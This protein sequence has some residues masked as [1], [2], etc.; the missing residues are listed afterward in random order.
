MTAPFARVGGHLLAEQVPL[1]AIASAVGTPTYV[2]SA[3]SLRSQFARLDAALAGV[4]HRIHYAMKANG[5]L[6][7]LRVLRAAG[8]HVDCVSSG[9]LF[10]ARA[11]G[12]EPAEIIVGGVGKREDEI[13]A[14][15]AAGVAC[16]TA[17]SYEELELI[18]AVALRR[19]VVAP[20][21][22]R[23]NP[24][25]TVHAFHEYV[26]TGQAGDKFGIPL[27]DAAAVIT[28]AHATLPGLRFVALQHHIGSLLTE[29]GPYRAAAD[30]L[31][32]L[33]LALRASAPAAVAQV[34]TLDLGGGFAIS[35][36]DEP[37]VDLRPLTETARAA[38]AATGCAIAIEPG[39]FLVAEAGLLLTRVLYRKQGGGREFVVADAGMNDLLRPALYQ[40]HHRIEAVEA[41]QGE[42]PVDVVGPVC[43]SGDFLARE[44]PLP[45]VRPGALL[46]VHT[47]G[48]YGFVMSSNYNARPRAAE[49]LVDGARWGVIRAR[50]RHEDLVR[51]ER[52]DPDWSVA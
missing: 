13:D 4:P 34:A 40:A 15:L 51:G 50:E 5:A 27:G 24:E 1:T 42:R 32:A 48:A 3:A 41:V 36:Q 10:R 9:E 33:L 20:V 38:H 35:Y 14:A 23:V 37:P 17:E 26:K 6:G 45:D 52:V 30:K 39:R 44:R 21:A 8:A 49:V 25:V 16:I 43:E 7:V 22:I 12:F 18:S 2:Y 28:R 47:A 11:A 29:L 46:A 31:V 19:G